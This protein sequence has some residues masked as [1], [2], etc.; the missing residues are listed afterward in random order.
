[1]S[2]PLIQIEDVYKRFGDNQVLNGASLSIRKGEVGTIIGKSGGGKSVL[3]KHIIGLLEPDAGRILF[4][5]RSLSEMKKKEKRAFKRKFS[6]M[7]QGTALFDSMTVFDNIALPLKERTSLG[8]TDIR[9]QVASK[10]TQLD[11]ATIEDRYPSQ[12]SGGMKKRVALARALITDPEIVLF[13]EPTTGLDPIRKNAVH[14]MISEYQQRFGFTGI[15]VSH[16]IPDIFFISQHIAML[17]NGKILFEGTPIEIQTQS[18]PIVQEFIR[19]LESQ[20][21]DMTGL[22][23]MPHGAERFQEEVSKLQRHETAFSIVVFHVVNLDEVN[24]DPIS[25]DRGVVLKRFAE[26]LQDRLRLSDVGCRYGLDKVMVLL[27]NTDVK[28]AQWACEKFSGEIELN[29]ISLAIQPYPGFCLQVNAGFVE[30]KEDSQLEQVL[31]RA[32]SKPSIA[33]EFRVC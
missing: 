10:M 25:K 23:S 19:G 29:D 18:D 28:Q 3:L 9:K 15:V 16:E 8:D 6:Y 33:Y 24:E 12:L 11:L 5:G 4:M 7:F 20:H 17:D 14:S 26:V 13:D 1:M 32:Q 21:D 30:V 27:P 2:Q 31:A 22:A